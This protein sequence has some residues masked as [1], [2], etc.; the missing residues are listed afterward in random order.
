[1]ICDITSFRKSCPNKSEAE[2][3]DLVRLALRPDEKLC[4]I[5]GNVAYTRQERRFVR[6]LINVLERLL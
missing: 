5:H 4:Y 2:I 6:V 1:M 3:A